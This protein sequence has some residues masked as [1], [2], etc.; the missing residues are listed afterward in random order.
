MVYSTRLE[1]VHLR[2]SRVRIP[3][4][5]QSYAK[6]SELHAFLSYGVGIAC[7]F[8]LWC[9]NCMPYNCSVY[10]YTYIL[11]SSKSHIFYFGSTIDLK[12]RLL[13]Y[14]SGQIQSTKPHTPWKLI[15]Y[16]A[17]NTEKEARDFE[18]YLKTG[19]GKAFAYKR[20][21]SEALRKDF[22]NGRIPK[23]LRSRA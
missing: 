13:L 12:A 1:S 2:V 19:S 6:A 8:I 3:P 10:Y 21:V 23:V 5:P 15:W 11:L 14:N 9:R 4:P 16:G 22:G 20:F 7:L 18:I 17:F